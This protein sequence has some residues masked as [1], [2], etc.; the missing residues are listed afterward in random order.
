MC[1]FGAEVIGG[2]VGVKFISRDN[3]FTKRSEREKNEE[4]M[5]M[6]VVSSKAKRLLASL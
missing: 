5:I 3:I 2:T 4:V 6:F 1:I